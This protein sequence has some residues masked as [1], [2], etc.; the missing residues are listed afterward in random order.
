L[1]ALPHETAH[2]RFRYC[3][4]TL[5]PNPLPDAMRGVPLFAWS[6]L[7]CAQNLVNELHHRTQPGLVPHRQFAFRRDRTRQR[8]PHHPPVHAQLLR[9]RANR[10]SSMRMFSPDLFE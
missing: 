10:T 2:S 3:V 6:Q 4:G 9:D 5:L 1:L 7:I 8:L